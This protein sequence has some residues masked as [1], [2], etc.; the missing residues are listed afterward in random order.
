MA[1]E[2]ALKTVYNV[3]KMI[4]RIHSNSHRAITLL[5]QNILNHFHLP[6]FNF[7]HLQLILMILDSRTCVLL[8]D[9]LPYIHTIEIIPF[10][11]RAFNEIMLEFCRRRFSSTIASVDLKIEKVLIQDWKLNSG[12]GTVWE[13][14]DKPVTGVNSIS[15]KHFENMFLILFVNIDL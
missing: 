12:I 1:N 14:P 13:K 4:L 11:G 2:L 10:T 9:V 15:K 8:Q 3:N 5:R 7:Q 6:S